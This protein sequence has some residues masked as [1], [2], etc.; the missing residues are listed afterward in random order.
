MARWSR[1][2][3]LFGPEPKA[4]V[5]AELSFH[6]EM[7]ARELIE[8]GVPPER[9][10][11]LALRRFG[12]YESSRDACVAISKRRGRRMARTEYLTELRRMSARARCCAPGSASR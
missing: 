2:R 11:A 4:D 8:Q 7:R 5:D 9:A 6:V 12:D 3:R 10:R 1:F